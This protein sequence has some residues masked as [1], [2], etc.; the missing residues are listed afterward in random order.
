LS[1][2]L[3]VLRQHGL[4]RPVAVYAFSWHA[5][6]AGNDVE[7]DVKDGLSATALV[8]LHDAHAAGVECFLHA[9]RDV[10][11]RLDQL[12][13]RGRLDVEKDY[14]LAPS[15]LPACGRRTAASRP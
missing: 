11:R 8:E 3:G 4:V 14:A 12:R 7:V 9:T 15:V 10:L 1:H 13:Q 2:A 5:F 6:V